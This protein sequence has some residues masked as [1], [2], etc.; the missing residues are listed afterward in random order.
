MS[1]LTTKAIVFED[2]GM[3]VVREIEIPE[4]TADDIVVE[5]E[6][7]G[8]SVGTERWALI[9]KREEIAFPNVPGYMGI[10]SVVQVGEEAARIGYCVGQ[11]VNFFASR[12]L[13]PYDNSWMGAHVARA[14]LNVTETPQPGQLDVHRCEFVPEALSP[15]G[16]SLCGL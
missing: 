12:I 14:V 7:S 11:M 15:V 5:T 4:P 8:V 10:G 2:I 3:A 16:A 13:P 1:T 9:G 6:V